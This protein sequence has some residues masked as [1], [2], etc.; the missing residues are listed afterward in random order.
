MMR[1]GPD[2]YRLGPGNYR[3]SKR[4]L[5]TGRVKTYI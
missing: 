5:W 4:K 1:P 2:F 3:L